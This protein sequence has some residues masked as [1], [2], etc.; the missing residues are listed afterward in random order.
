MQECV[1]LSV[2]DAK[3]MI[4]IACVQEMINVKQSIELMKLKVKLPMEIEV[5]AKVL[6]NNRSIGGRTSHVSIRLN[7]L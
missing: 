1:N 6:V 7:F 3:L 4:L 2:S 5:D